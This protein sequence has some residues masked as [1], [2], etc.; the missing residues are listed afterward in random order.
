MWR[1]EATALTDEVT[2]TDNWLNCDWTDDE[3]L[4][5]TDSSIPA[6]KSENASIR[7]S[8]NELKIKKKLSH[9]F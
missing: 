3:C 1:Q 2:Q 6:T 9:K 4:R 5:F 8:T 7:Q